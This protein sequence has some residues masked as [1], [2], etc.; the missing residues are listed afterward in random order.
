MLQADSDEVR[1]FSIVTCYL[2]SG[3]LIVY[4]FLLPLRCTK[5]FVFKTSIYRTSCET[6]VIGL[7]TEYVDFVVKSVLFMHDISTD[8]FLFVSYS[9]YLFLARMR[10]T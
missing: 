9:S 2:G 7:F 8:C 4:I 10:K 6:T 3:I 5:I 1:Q